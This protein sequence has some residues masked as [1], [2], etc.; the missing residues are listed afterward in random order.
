[1]TAF[2]I[3]LTDHA[4]ERFR[5]R[6]RPALD[7]EHAADELARLALFGDIVE[8]P[9]EWHLRTAAQYASHYLVIGDLVLPLRPT[10]SGEHL[11]V[12][13]LVRGLR[14]D[15]ARQRRRGA[16]QASA[17]FRSQSGRRPTKVKA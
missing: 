11:A 10:S 14:S 7:L 12:T 15:V 4:V 8:E 3:T 1:M 5:E 6:A 16:R 9:P 13:C 17:R 2:S